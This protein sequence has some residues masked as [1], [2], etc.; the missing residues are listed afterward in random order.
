MNEDLGKRIGGRLRKLRKGRDLNQK[1]AAAL[2]RERTERKADYTYIGKI[3]R[4][5]QFPSVKYLKALA[6]TFSI[7]MV[8]FLE[9]DEKAEEIERIKRGLTL[10]EKLER[11]SPQDR[12]FIERLIKRLKK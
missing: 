6:D 9:E 1:A 4:G 8:Y 10:L 3:E 2:V 11:L 5:K 12:E 7:P